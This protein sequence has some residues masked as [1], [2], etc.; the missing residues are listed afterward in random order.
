MFQGIQTDA[1]GAEIFEYNLAGFPVYANDGMASSLEEC[2]KL[3]HWHDDFELI[4]VVSGRMGMY[5]DGEDVVMGEGQG[6]FV[7]SGLMHYGH[8]IEGYDSEYRCVLIHPELFSNVELVRRKYI[9]TLI[10]DGTFRYRVFDRRYVHDQAIIQS[11]DEIFQLFHKKA[12]ILELEVTTQA[13]TVLE[14]LYHIKNDYEAFVPQADQREIALRNMIKY[15]Q[16]HYQEPISLT[17][18]AAAGMVSKSLCNIIFRDQL[19]Q[20]PIGY[21]VKYRIDK[22]MEL[23]RTTNMSITDV[24]FA[25][26]FNGQ[27]YFSEIFHRQV[28]MSPKAYRQQSKP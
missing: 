4:V 12:G 14:H 18:L 16:Q 24:A 28:G 26:G 25:V 10:S 27:S 2:E 15:I 3:C 17:K 20:T 5:I 1:N 22:S 11:V 13:F 23:L 6:I 19:N 8:P 21:L 7:N 9:Q